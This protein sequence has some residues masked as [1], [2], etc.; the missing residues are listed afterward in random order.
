MFQKN[1]FT[2]FPFFFTLNIVTELR[3]RSVSIFQYFIIF[4]VFGS[5][6]INFPIYNELSGYL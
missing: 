5:V 4:K 2:L 1:G 6:K 3:I